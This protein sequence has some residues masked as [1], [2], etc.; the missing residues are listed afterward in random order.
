MLST[1]YPLDTGRKLKTRYS[2]NF[3]PPS[4][5][6]VFARRNEIPPKI[7]TLLRSFQVKILTKILGQ[8]LLSAQNLRESQLVVGLDE[9]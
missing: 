8:H 5:G 7:L 3:V 9:K 6:Y 2:F 4:R 1:P